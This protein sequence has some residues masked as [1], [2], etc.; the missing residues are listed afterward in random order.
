MS[1]T[2][3]QSQQTRIGIAMGP[4]PKVDT[5][6]P[7]AGCLLC[8]AAASVAN[9]SLTAHTQKLPKDDVVRIKDDLA[10][11]LRKKG[12][13][14]TMIPGDFIADKLPKAGGG[15][16][17]PDYDFSSLKD[18]YQIDK[19]VVIQITQL[20]ISRNYSAYVPNGAPQGVVAGVGYMVN[21]ADNSYEWYVP[22]NRIR[23]AAGKWDEAPD[24]PGLTNAYFQAVEEARD[25]L[26]QPFSN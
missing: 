18:K 12:Y 2:A 20:G 21:L 19:L 10:E 4:V 24:Y 13:T 25:V 23:S 26:L 16:N 7:G 14:P 11:V 5:A 1:S 6:F 9:S 3:L 22:L 8:L 15:P 17:K